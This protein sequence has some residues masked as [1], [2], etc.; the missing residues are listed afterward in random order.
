VNAFI[1]LTILAIVILFERKRLYLLGDKYSKFE[2]LL[3]LKSI[4]L[5]VFLLFGY[6]LS[7]VGLLT[8]DVLLVLII[9]IIFF[10]LIFVERRPN[11]HLKV[12][13]PRDF[14]LI[15]LNIFVLLFLMNNFSY[16]LAPVQNDSNSYALTGYLTYANSGLNWEQR[17]D[18]FVLEEI[19]PATFQDEN[20]EYIRFGMPLYLSSTGLWITLF[21][22]EALW[23]MPFMFMAL[24]SNL[25]MIVVLSVSDRKS[26]LI[27]TTIFLL[28]PVTLLI[29]NKLF[30]ENFTILLV[31]LYLASVLTFKSE[32]KFF[33]LFVVFMLSLIRI[34]LIVFF[35]IWLIVKF[36]KKEFK[37]LSYG[38]ISFAISFLHIL[39]VNAAYLERDV[40][41]RAS[42]FLDSFGLNFD[43]NIVLLVVIGLIIFLFLLFVFSKLIKFSYPYLMVLVLVSFLGLLSFRAIDYYTSS[44]TSVD[45]N[46]VAIYSQE[47]S[48]MDQ[49]IMSRLGEITSGI[50]IFLGYFGLMQLVIRKKMLELMPLFAFLLLFLFTAQHDPNIVPWSRRYIYLVI[51]FLY[52]GAAY[53]LSSLDYRTRKLTLIL[54]LVFSLISFFKPSSL[55]LRT[56]EYREAEGLISFIEENLDKDSRI[57]VDR[58]SDQSVVQ[59]LRICETLDIVSDYSCQY[60]I[61]SIDSL[62]ISKFDYYI[63]MENID[64]P[65]IVFSARYRL[66]LVSYPVEYYSWPDEAR[67][68]LFDVFIY[69]VQL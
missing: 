67:S 53:I 41:E 30:N 29:Y 12:F 42:R 11:L 62:D 63:S 35:F 54:V 37:V 4:F 24:A 47:H 55:I 64:S 31:L 7:L 46:T 59:N 20:G 51:P 23:L 49:I 13:H 36:I 50:L 17:D 2:N 16:W 1:L 33:E 10:A 6:L 9:L 14:F 34:E 44:A 60:S 39:Y 56:A 32:R 8:Q 19:Y 69:R 68:A 27:Y 38:F 28:S 66:S 61:R 57:V 21:G 58:R 65:K 26:I 25:F 15:G 18:D 43:L 52:V 5:L 3:F 40:V 22:V 48:N 45:I